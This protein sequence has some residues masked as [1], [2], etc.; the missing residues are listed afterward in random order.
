M[1]Y[2]H[3]SYNKISSIATYLVQKV[4][5][6]FEITEFFFKLNFLKIRYKVNGE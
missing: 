6:V 3:E 4:V 1:W 5:N 2:M